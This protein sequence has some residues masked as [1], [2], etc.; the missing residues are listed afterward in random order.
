MGRIHRQRRQHR[1]D[2][3]AEVLVDPGALLAIELLV[4]EHLHAVLSQLGPQG[5]AVVL[6]LLLQQWRN[7]VWIAASCS[8]GLRPST[9]GVSMPASTCDFSEATRTMKNSSRLLL[10]IAL[11]LAC[12]S[13]GVRGPWPGPAPAG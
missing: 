2:G 3:A 11:N 4:I 8:S 13:S 5:V 9:L 10:K 1:K 7:L 6:L 12:S